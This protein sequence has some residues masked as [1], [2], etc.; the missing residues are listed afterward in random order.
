M[1]RFGDFAALPVSA[2][3]HGV[4]GFVD[5][6]VGGRR[7][8]A[9]PI[10]HG[11]GRFERFDLGTLGEETVIEEGVLI[12]NPWCVHLGSRV[13]VGHRTLF[14]GDTRGELRVEDAA[15]IGQDCY[16]HSAGGI[17]IGT[18]VGIGPRVMILTSTH[19]ETA[20]PTPIID[21]PLRFAPVEIGAG[22]DI[23]IGAILLPGAKIGA[24]TQIG[25]GA[26]VTGEIPAGVVAIGMPARFVR[27]RGEKR[28][29]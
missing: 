9:R 17:T 22:C 28:A 23:G 29:D 1:T 5:P 7:R 10:T 26:V 8:A 15:W 25:A 27:R 16:M 2:D 4:T 12:M 13:Y 3:G 11:S 14:N 18:S 24:G 6:E 20:P 21:A 19:E